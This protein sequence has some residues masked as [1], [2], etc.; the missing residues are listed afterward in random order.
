LHYAN[1]GIRRLMIR[2]PG[3]LP[4]DRRRFKAFRI[5]YSLEWHADKKGPGGILQIEPEADAGTYNEGWYDASELLPDIAPMRSLLISGD[6]RPLY[7]AWLACYGEDE[8]REPPVPAGLG[9][10]PPAL[11]AMAEF[12]ELSEDL[13]AAAAERSPPLPE[14]TGAAESLEHWLARQ[15]RDDLREL[16]RQFLAEDTDAARAETLARVRD[17]T[18]AATWPLAEP[19]RTWAQLREAA[20]RLRDERQRREQQTR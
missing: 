13:L 15:T 8:L 7:L 5:P 17:E 16:V 20:S 6:L 1:F 9:K 12:Y 18:G 3:G 4:C 19:T 11:E 2:L 10:L 14:T